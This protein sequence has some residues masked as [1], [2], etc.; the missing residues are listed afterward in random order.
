[1]I[2][3]WNKLTKIMVVLFS[4]SII[5]CASIKKYRIEK[6]ELRT[7]H[8]FNQWHIE[9]Q[10]ILEKNKAKGEL[11]KSINKILKLYLSKD[12]KTDSKRLFPKLEY[13]ILDENIKI[14]MYKKL[15]QKPNEQ[16]LIFSEVDFKHS[17]NNDNSDKKILIFTPKY[18]KILQKKLP[19]G[20]TDQTEKQNENAR[21]VLIKIGE[22]Y[23]YEIPAQIYI[24]FNQELNS[25][26]VYRYRKDS[27]G[28][29]FWFRY[30]KQNKQWKYDG[31]KFNIR[32]P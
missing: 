3:I 10:Q 13:R 12:D 30:N 25:A 23:K 18:Q 17:L 32:I 15:G 21:A 24:L 27:F 16:D 19:Y 6:K 20:F 26:I 28:K 11:Q 7:Q 1:M 9:T 4:F 29:P 2:N 5:S 14:S 8:F 31:I 22:G